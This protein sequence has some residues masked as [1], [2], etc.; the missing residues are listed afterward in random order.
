MRQSM[1][2][3]RTVECLL[4]NEDDL[5]NNDAILLQPLVHR[6]LHK[7]VSP[8][9]NRLLNEEAN[10]DRM[11]RIAF[12]INETYSVPYK[13]TDGRVKS[14]QAS[15]NIADCINTILKEHSEEELK[16]KITRIDCSKVER[17]GVAVD[18]IISSLSSRNPIILIEN[19]TELPESQRRCDIANVLIHSWA[20]D[21]FVF[22]DDIYDTRPHIVIF[23]TRPKS[24]LGDSY[25]PIWHE[26]DKFEWHGNI[27]P[28]RY[29]SRFLQQ[30]GS[31]R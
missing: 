17:M 9:L 31:K 3:I 7:I 25:Y 4:D 2:F 5:V 30:N 26:W 27:L 18:F 15:I 29:H 28:R 22:L 12:E 10:T 19:I 11:L 1:D 13:G 20:K 8:Y 14:S 6:K 23:T 16:D 24:E 21:D